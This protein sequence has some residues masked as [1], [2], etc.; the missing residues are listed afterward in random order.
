MKLLLELVH[1]PIDWYAGSATVEVVST[2]TGLRVVVASTEEFDSYV[3]FHFRQSHAFQVLYERDMMSYWQEPLPANH[4]LFRVLGGG[5]LERTSSD[6]FQVANSLNSNEW[7]I[8]S[9]T[10][11]CVTIIADKEPAVRE[12]SV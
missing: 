4:M 8:V 10:G 1:S 11:P 7:L 6:Y 3:E 5:W 9:D 12:Y 2:A